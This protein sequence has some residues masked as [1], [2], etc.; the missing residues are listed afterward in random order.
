MEVKEAVGRE[1]VKNLEIQLHTN[2]TIQEVTATIAGAGIRIRILM[3]L[4]GRGIVAPLRP[5]GIKAAQ[6]GIE[7]K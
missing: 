2:A 6:G 5:I 7:S 3:D 4:V 1:G